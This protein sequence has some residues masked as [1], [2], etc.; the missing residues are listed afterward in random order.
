MHII[1]LSENDVIWK[2]KMAAEDQVVVF[3]LCFVLVWVWR[4]CT[5][6][7]SAVRARDPATK[8]E[9]VTFHQLQDKLNWVTMIMHGGFLSLE[10]GRD[11]H[12][13]WGLWGRCFS[14]MLFMDVTIRN[15]RKPS[16]SARLHFIFFVPSPDLASSEN[17]WKGGGALVE[18]SPSSLNGW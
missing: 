1:C 9:I 2:R 13:G 4:R 8:R 15:I 14:K 11:G 3:I 5:Q 17:I 12:Y 16:K 7:C 6:Q 18:Q 10:F